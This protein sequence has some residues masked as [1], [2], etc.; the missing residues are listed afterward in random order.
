VLAT[1]SALAALHDPFDGQPYRY[2]REA[3]GGF[4]L[5]GVGQNLQDDGGAF[6]DLSDNRANY[7]TGDVVWRVPGR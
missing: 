5:W 6:P 4:T 3:D 1:A 2:R 7:E